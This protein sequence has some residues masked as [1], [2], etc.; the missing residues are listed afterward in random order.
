MCAMGDSPSP[1]AR[2]VSKRG[3]TI[4]SLLFF[5]TSLT[6]S[7]LQESFSSSGRG[8][9]RHHCTLRDSR[10]LFLLPRRESGRG[11]DDGR[12]LIRSMRRV[13]AQSDVV[14]KQPP[15]D[16]LR[17]EADAGDSDALYQLGV[18]LRK[19]AKADRSSETMEA[20]FDYLYKAAEAGHAK[21]QFTTGLMLFKGQGVEKDE[22]IGKY[23][24][25][26]AAE[27]GHLRSQHN[28]AMLYYEGRMSEDGKRSTLG[29][30]YWFKKAAEGG[31]AESQYR[32]GGMLLSG[33][34]VIRNE[35]W[36]A[37]LLESAAEQGHTQA[38]EAV[39]LLY[40]GG[41][42]VEQDARSAAAWLQKAGQQGN[43]AEACYS[44]A[45]MLREGEG[46]LSKDPSAA[47]R[48]LTRAAD[49]GHA[50]SARELAVMYLSGEGTAVDEEGA[51]YWFQRADEIEADEYDPISLDD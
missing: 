7:F 43:D 4:L 27:N 2:R 14:E 41:V 37:K 19:Q 20:A 9:R 22:A 6:L 29:A 10:V 34:G 42:G 26:K 23:Y 36:A 31:Y 3:K 12:S 44:L 35:T 47:I 32:L 16:T 30:A 15:L 17:E 18:R 45:C 33:D 24:L 48:W 13:Q 40:R 5:T 21:A 46:K 1:H 11:K 25:N 38:Q 51:A 8:G 49:N 50:E 28:V 39:G